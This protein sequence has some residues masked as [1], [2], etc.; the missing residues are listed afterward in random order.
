MEKKSFEN[1]KM[2]LR[3]YKEAWEE[4]DEKIQEHFFKEGVLKIFSYFLQTNN[5][6]GEMEEIL[7]LAFSW[8]HKLDEDK[9][10]VLSESL[11]KNSE[12]KI[13]GKNEE[14]RREFIQDF[15][16]NKIPLHDIILVKEAGEIHE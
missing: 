8:Y 7:L 4:V 16:H 11:A 6:F 5:S 2:H 10:N 9:K 13:F 1:Q 12:G 15:F 14:E 3:L